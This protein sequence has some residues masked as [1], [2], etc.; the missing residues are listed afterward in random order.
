MKKT[1]TVTKLRAKSSAR[2][3]G[4]VMEDYLHIHQWFDETETW[5]P[6]ERH[7][8]F[9]HHAQGIFE[10]EKRFGYTIKNSNGK[11]IPTRVI[12]ENHVTED[13]GFIPTAEQWLEHIG[14]NKWMGFRDKNLIFALRKE[15]EE[16]KETVKDII[17]KKNRVV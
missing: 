13:I 11:E 2:K 14:M 17:T 15:S 12:C 5:L 7:M 3:F 4:G 6:D 10:A 9:R 1:N 16:T 8:A